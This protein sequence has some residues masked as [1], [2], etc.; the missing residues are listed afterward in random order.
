MGSAKEYMRVAEELFSD[1][2]CKHK[3]ATLQEWMFIHS[4][5]GKAEKLYPKNQPPSY[6]IYELKCPCGASFIDQEKKKVKG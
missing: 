4:Y 1:Y 6:K 5:H 3:T 2:Y